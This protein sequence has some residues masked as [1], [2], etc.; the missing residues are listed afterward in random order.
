MFKYKDK[1]IETER[2]LLRLFNKA[3]A[4]KVALICNNYSIYRSTVSLPHPYTVDYAISWIEK[5]VQKFDDEL[6]YN[7]A[8]AD[9][10]SGEIYGFVGVSNNKSHNNGEI[11]YWI[12]E[13]YWGRGYATE[14][15]SALIRFA[16]EEK[17]LHRVFARHLSSNPSSGKVMTK[18]GMTYEGTQIEQVVKLGFYEDVVFY[19]IINPKESKKHG[20]ET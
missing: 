12:G 20:R 8:V 1:T 3:D 19:G 14:A 4:E 15:V 11:G 10:Q 18:A 17:G 16:F 5:N 6:A 9:K 2:L 13:E 7:F